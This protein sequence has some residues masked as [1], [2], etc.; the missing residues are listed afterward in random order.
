MYSI[1]PVPVPERDQ[2]NQQYPKGTLSAIRNLFFVLP[3]FLLLLLSLYALFGAILP[4]LT[5]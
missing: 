1:R 2:G 5:T 4:Q 3:Y